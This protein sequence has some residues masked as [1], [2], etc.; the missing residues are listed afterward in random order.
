MQ[1]WLSLIFLLQIIHSHK[2]EAAH[3]LSE[4][5]IFVKFNCPE[6]TWSW[7]FISR[8]KSAT[9]LFM[10]NLGVKWRIAAVVNFY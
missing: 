9:V 2:S 6:R 10:R 4:A 7:L 3:M 1:A 5:D 8:N